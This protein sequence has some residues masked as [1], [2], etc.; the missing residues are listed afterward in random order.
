MQ[1]TKIHIQKSDEAVWLKH[2]VECRIKENMSLKRSTGFL[3]DWNDRL[4]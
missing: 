1:R 4:Q 2:V 3:A